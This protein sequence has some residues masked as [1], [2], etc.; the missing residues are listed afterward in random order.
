MIGVFTATAFIPTG[1]E[2]AVAGGTTVAAQKVL[3]AIFGDQ[4][5]RRLAERSRTLLLERVR[6]LLDEDAARFRRVL[7]EAETTVDTPARLRAA[8]SRVRAQRS[9]L[10]DVAVADGLAR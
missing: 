9:E 10:L 3:E 1:A 4:A 7:A 6:A 2:I 5:I 8:A